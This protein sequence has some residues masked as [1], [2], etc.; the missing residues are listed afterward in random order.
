MKKR[1]FFSVTLCVI[2]L[3]QNQR[4]QFSKFSDAWDNYMAEYEQAAYLSL[5]QLTQ[6]QLQEARN[7]RNNISKNYPIIGKPI[8]KKIIDYQNKEKAL[9]QM[10]KYDAAERIK[11]KREALE[12]ADMADFL[13]QDIQRLIR[14]QEA[15][16]KIK[17]E[18]AMA[19][20][21]K[22]IQRD[23]NEQLLHRQI[24]SKR[25]I[26][27]SKNLIKNIQKKQEMEAK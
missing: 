9:T 20:L 14:K 17:H 13:Q 10:K 8:N 2:C 23:R 25:M 1:C 5:E 16:L 27:R 19:A 11:R 4:E 3:E 24:D 12:A 7:L 18:V 15:K 21:L 26:Q 22:R 6:D